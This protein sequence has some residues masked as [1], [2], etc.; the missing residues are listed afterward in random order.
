M[1]LRAIRG[2][3]VERW[4]HLWRWRRRLLRQ[5]RIQLREPSR[6]P[7]VNRHCGLQ[8][9]TCERGQ[10][11]RNEQQCKTRREHRHRARARK[12]S[13]VRWPTLK[14]HLAGLGC[15]EVGAVPTR[16][17]VDRRGE[18]LELLRLQPG[19]QHH[20]AVRLSRLG[21]RVSSGF[22]VRLW[23]RTRPR[24]DPDP[25]PTR[26]RP[27]P[28]RPRP[29]PKLPRYRAARLEERRGAPRPCVAARAVGLERL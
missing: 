29:K 26:P 7:C 18:C 14:S 4:D 19:W 15:E 25:T 1:E 13:N 28:T 20:D 12:W 3:L 16:R 23:G 24:P 2:I 11:R 17:A 27:A 9:K 22:W 6:L 10:A 5:R 21:L 8:S